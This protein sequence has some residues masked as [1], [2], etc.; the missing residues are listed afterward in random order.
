[1]KYTFRRTRT[2]PLLERNAVVEKTVRDIF[3]AGAE[4]LLRV[5][6][7]AEKFNDGIDLL[8]I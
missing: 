7:F 8:T 4:C 5:P 6:D 1:M 3:N 2:I